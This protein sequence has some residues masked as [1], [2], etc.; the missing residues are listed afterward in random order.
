MQRAKL[1]YASMSA[2]RIV[3]C[4]NPLVAHAH[5]SVFIAAIWHALSKRRSGTVVKI[6]GICD[7]VVRT[8][9]PSVASYR[10]TYR[11]YSLLESTRDY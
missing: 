11:S 5:G 7:E 10:W 2:E 1:L 3:A 4:Y 8:E 6:S 9:L